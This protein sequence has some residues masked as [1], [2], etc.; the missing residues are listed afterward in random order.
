[1]E[2]RKPTAFFKHGLPIP[3]EYAGQPLGPEFFTKTYTVYHV[4]TRNENSPLWEFPL[5]MIPHH[6]LVCHVHYYEHWSV[7][8]EDWSSEN[9][10]WEEFKEEYITRKKERVEKSLGN[11]SRTTS[12]SEIYRP[13][14]PD[15][16]TLDDLA[17][18][19]V[20]KIPYA[21]TERDA[22]ETVLY[23]KDLSIVYP[24]DPKSL[25]LFRERLTYWS[26]K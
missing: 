11:L 20:H 26:T 5:F 6:S 7:K 13:S 25:E 4:I 8:G 12:F 1:M 3:L 21:Y 24:L 9:K 22:I 2:E 15:E 16:Q 10:E 23:F 18:E 19:V 17:K 14:A